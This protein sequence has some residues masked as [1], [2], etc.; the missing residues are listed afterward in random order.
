M[1]SIEK[2]KQ[3]KML[4]LSDLDFN[5]KEERVKKQLSQTKV[6]ILCGVS[7]VSYQRWENASTKKIKVNHFNKLKEI[8]GS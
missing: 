8:L 3:N 2:R 6:A 5:L 1:T 4:N 7:L